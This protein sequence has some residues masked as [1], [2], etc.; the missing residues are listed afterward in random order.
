MLVP[1]RLSLQQDLASNLQISSSI[2]LSLSL[3]GRRRVLSAYQYLRL[4]TTDRPTRTSF[5]SSLSINHLLWPAI[6]LPNLAA[7]DTSVTA[8]DR[9]SLNDMPRF[10][11]V[12]AFAIFTADIC[13]VPVGKHHIILA[14]TVTLRHWFVD[15]Y[16]A[17]PCRFLSRLRLCRY[18]TSTIL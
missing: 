15:I 5:V 16:K 1:V 17:R 18:T 13:I 11:E 2:F 6:Y 4:C 3:A 14:I 7:G 8:I 9:R 12:I 10:C